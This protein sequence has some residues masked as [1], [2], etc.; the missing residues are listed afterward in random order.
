MPKKLWYP[1]AK[2]AS[3]SSIITRNS[4]D[5][6]LAF[7]SFSSFPLTAVVATQRLAKSNVMI[8][9][10]VASTRFENMDMAASG[11]PT[12]VSNPHSKVCSI[13]DAHNKGQLLPS[14]FRFQTFH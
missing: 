2:K 10:F 11:S 5:A 4:E 14:L 8:V 3:I 13:I 6:L 1:F 9:V 7:P 12:K